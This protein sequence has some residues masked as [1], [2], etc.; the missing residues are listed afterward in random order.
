MYYGDVHSTSSL[1]HDNI[2]YSYL[3]N[4]NIPKITE[5]QRIM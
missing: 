2:T 1:E 3:N 4:F 5:I